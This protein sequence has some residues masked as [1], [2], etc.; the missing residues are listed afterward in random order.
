MRRRTEK[1]SQSLSQENWR[2]NTTSE[3]D[4]LFLHSTLLYMYSL[5]TRAH[6]H[7]HA[8]A[9]TLMLPCIRHLVGAV[10]LWLSIC[11]YIPM[12]HT[13]REYRLCCRCEI[14]ITFRNSVQFVFQIKYT[15]SQ[16]MENHKGLVYWTQ[17]LRD[18]IVTWL[19]DDRRALDWWLDLL[20]SFTARDYTLQITVTQTSVL[21]HV[22]WQRLPT[23]AVN[24]RSAGTFQLLPTNCHSQ[25]NY[26]SE[27]E[28]LYHWLFTDSQFILVPSL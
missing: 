7:T 26:R 18:G 24:S 19:S 27:S 11:A 12:L 17:I 23:S 3:V 2:E 25:T 5:H 14:C 28:L 15:D 22:A 8:H 9:H 10:S 4:D 16:Y 13:V 20:D 1:I 6:G 21:S